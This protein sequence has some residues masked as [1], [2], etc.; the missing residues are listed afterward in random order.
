VSIPIVPALV[1]LSHRER[2]CADTIGT[3]PVPGA[4]HFQ[5]WNINIFSNKTY[6]SHFIKTAIGNRYGLKLPKCWL[7][8][9]KNYC[10]FITIFGTLSFPK[11]TFSNWPRAESAIVQSACVAC[12]AGGRSACCCGRSSRTARSRTRQSRSSHSVDCSTPASAWVVRASLQAP[13][14]YCTAVATLRHEEA[15]ASSLY[16]RWYYM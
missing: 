2:K 11:G 8:F 4:G 13:C 15:V 7:P 3:V 9:K 6:G 14:Q 5:C 16:V 10:S 12:T 1:I